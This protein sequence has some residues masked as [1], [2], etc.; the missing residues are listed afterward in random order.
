MKQNYTPEQLIQ[1]IYLEFDLFDRLE[2]EFALEEDS[3][4]YDEY[5]QLVQTLVSLDECLMSP[6]QSLIENIL[7]YAR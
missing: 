1:F 5:Q 6:R 4:L 3:K 7:Q 2:L